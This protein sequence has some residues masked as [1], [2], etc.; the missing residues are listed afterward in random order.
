M[1]RRLALSVAGLVVATTLTACVGQEVR[2]TEDWLVEQPHVASIEVIDSTVDELSYTATIRAELDADT[3]DEQALALV[4]DAL[5]YIDSQPGEDVTLQFGM[6]QVDFAVATTA[7]DYID[8]WRAVLE[9][10]D[11]VSALVSEDA[12][13]AQTLRSTAFAT[14]DALQ[15]LGGKRTV[16]GFHAASDFEDGAADFKPPVTLSGATDC[17]PD[18]NV[19]SLAQAAMVDERVTF[20]TL[21][22]C[23]LLD[24]TFDA[25]YPIG[26]AVLEIRQ[27]LDS[28]GLSDFPVTVSLSPETYGSPDVHIVAVTP[29]APEALAIAQTLESAGVAMRYELHAD[30][31]LRVESSEGTAAELVAIIAGSSAAASLGLI[32]VVGS[33]VSV[34]GTLTELLG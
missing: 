32:D 25:G 33:D 26:T 1:R 27:Q 21:D 17:A 19:L 2:H 10:P 29:G 12:V 3:T 22:L 5:A 28:V 13:E 8:D 23:S 30:R 24:V 20:G 14:Y 16:Y 18:P 7:S 11:V 34:S 4:D 15:P 6:H 31:S 9:L